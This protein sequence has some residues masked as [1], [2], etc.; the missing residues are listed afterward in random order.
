MNTNV[1]RPRRHRAAP[2]GYLTAA[3]IAERQQAPLSSVYHWIKTGKLGPTHR[4]RN[5]LVVPTASADE[6]LVAVRP[7]QAGSGEG[8]VP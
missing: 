5:V 4:W 2:D 8:G 6:F 3:Q 7:V 1:R